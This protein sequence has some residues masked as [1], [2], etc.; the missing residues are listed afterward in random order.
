MGWTY[1]RGDDV[2]IARGR[3]ICGRGRFSCSLPDGL[4]FETT[5]DAD[6]VG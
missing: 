6:L 5:F 4:L 1:E 3:Y 2:G